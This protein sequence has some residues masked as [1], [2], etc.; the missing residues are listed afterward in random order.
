MPEARTI[1]FDID[2]ILTDEVDPTASIGTKNSSRDD[3]EPP[4]TNNV[5][6]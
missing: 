5:N 1:N 6:G 2:R 3:E 4:I